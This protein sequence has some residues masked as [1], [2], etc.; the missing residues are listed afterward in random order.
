MFSKMAVLDFFFISTSLSPFHIN[1]ALF[2]LGLDEAVFPCVIVAESV[3][4][5]DDCE[6]GVLSAQ[7]SSGSQRSLAR[8][9]L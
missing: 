1:V 2:E 9:K 8:K 6:S 3:V 5:I 4:G 7:N